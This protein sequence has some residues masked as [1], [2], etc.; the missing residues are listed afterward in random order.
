MQE[1]ENLGARL[2]WY[3][4]KLETQTNQGSCLEVFRT[5]I[6]HVANI[7][8]FGRV[9]GHSLSRLKDSDFTIKKRCLRSS[10][11]RLP[12]SILEIITC[13]PRYCKPGSAKYLP[14]KPLNLTCEQRP[15][16]TD[17]KFGSIDC[18]QGQYSRLF[19]M[20]KSKRYHQKVMPSAVKKVDF[21]WLWFYGT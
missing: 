20:F 15:S 16:F 5:L 21:G 9:S 11:S 13:P 17:A 1:F 3:T 12:P 2:V 6:V 10:C 8:I 19:P 7:P 14:P 18:F 4:P